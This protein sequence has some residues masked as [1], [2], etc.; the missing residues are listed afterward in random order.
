MTNA[1]HH[2]E[3]SAKK[4]GGVPEDYL[5]VHEWFDETKALFCDNRHRALRHH[6]EGIAMAVK[7]LGPIVVNSNGKKVPVREIGEQHVRED[8]GY[9]PPASDWLREIRPRAWMNRVGAKNPYDSE[10]RLK[11]PFDERQG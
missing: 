5:R 11:E 1:Y 3:S 4:W 10:G 6:A 2:A 9:I 7:M 8:L